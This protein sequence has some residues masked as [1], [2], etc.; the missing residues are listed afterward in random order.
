M[1]ALAI[2]FRQSVHSNMCS[3]GGQLTGVLGATQL[4]SAGVFAALLAVSGVHGGYE[5]WGGRGGAGEGISDGALCG[6]I[7]TEY[8]LRG[9]PQKPRRFH[10]RLLVSAEVSCRVVRS[11]SAR[12]VLYTMTV[13]YVVIKCPGP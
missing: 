3:T 9:L 8:I 7:V 5:P 2:L 4:E 6:A 10:A 13:L 1:T 11:G 12:S